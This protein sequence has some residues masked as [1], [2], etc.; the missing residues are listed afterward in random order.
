MQTLS[1]PNNTGWLGQYLSM[2]PAWL[3][4]FVVYEIHLEEKKTCSVEVGLACKR[5]HSSSLLETGLFLGTFLSLLSELFILKK[6][7]LLSN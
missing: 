4:A 6:S 7:L 2:Y 1:S 5:V 3:S